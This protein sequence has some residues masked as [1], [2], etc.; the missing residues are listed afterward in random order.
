MENLGRSEK[1]L[2]GYNF[3]IVLGVNFYEVNV[4]VELVRKKLEIQ[5]IK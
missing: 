3:V 4:C 2:Y 1:I 5:N